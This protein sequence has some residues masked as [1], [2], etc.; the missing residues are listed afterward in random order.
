VREP[1]PKKGENVVAN[2]KLEKFQQEEKQAKIQKREV[3]R[4]FE[5]Q[6][7][8]AR[9]ETEARDVLST[10]HARAKEFNL[11]YNAADLMKVMELKRLLDE[12]LENFIEI[13]PRQLMDSRLFLDWK[14]TSLPNFNLMLKPS[15]ASGNP[16]K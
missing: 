12:R 16:Q 15:Q 4:Y 14:K 3:E 10:A 6:E 11:D 8:I 13:R 1:E 7:K 9:L 2:F 5:L